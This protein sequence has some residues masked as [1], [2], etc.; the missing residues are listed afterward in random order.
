MEKNQTVQLNIE[1]VGMNGEGVARLDGEV[2]FVKNALPG[3]TCSAKILCAKKKFCYAV[4]TEITSKPSPVRTTPACP[5]FGKCGGCTL[6]HVSYE[7]QLALKRQNVQ[8]AFIKA[9]MSVAVSPAEASDK[10]LRYRNKMSLP[11][12][13][14]DGKPVVGLYAFNSHRIVET[15]DCLLQPDW[16]KTVI[17]VFKKFLTRS[18]YK[19]Y[20]E[21]KGSGDIRH[22][23]V[24]EVAGKLCISV[25]ATKNIDL[26][27]FAAL[28]KDKFA[29][30]SLYLN[31][32]RKNN[33]VILGDEWKLAYGN[34]NTVDV[35]GLKIFV[36]PAGFFQVNDYIRTRIY[37][38]VREI[39]KNASA[40]T[41]IDAYSGAGIMTAMLAGVANEVIGIEIN[42]EAT[43]SAKKLAR[44]ND[45]KNMTA[46]LG[47]VKTVLPSLKDKAEGCLIVLDPPRSGCDPNVLQSV[48]D[49]AP[50]TLVYVSCNPATLARDCKI[51]SDKYD[52]SEVQPFDMFPMTDHVETV[53]LLSRE[54]ADDHIRFSINTED[55]KKNVG[56]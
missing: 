1:N 53:V 50:E 33:N 36:H 28:L 51:L 17:A 46:L 43:E 22:L 2:V 13:Q 3:E 25:V 26:S 14:K 8:S 6:Q 19:G 32:N 48:K 23:V 42:R 21:L 40:K 16:N 41:I 15:D 54:K 56:G 12:G 49:F 34:E 31:I 5:A 47:D 7:Y 27:A 29:D 37:E 45:I 52:I 44:D 11:V 30:F 38:K 39:A 10:T 35:G 18:G 20:D 24:R 9:G 4:A 55:L